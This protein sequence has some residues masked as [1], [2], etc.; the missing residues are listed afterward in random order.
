MPL[1]TFRFGHR[2]RCREDLR[3]V[4]QDM[5]RSGL[6]QTACIQQRCARQALAET[7]VGVK[8]PFR[9]CFA[10]I[11][12]AGVRM[13]VAMARREAQGLNAIRLDGRR[14]GLDRDKQQEQDGKPTAH[15]RRL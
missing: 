13:V 1:G 15:G 4:D 9:L 11:H 8:L 12:L 10:F 2:C 5:G 7:A 6:R 14:S 3:G